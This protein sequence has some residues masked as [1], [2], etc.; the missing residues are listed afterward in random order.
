MLGI[1]QHH[2]GWRLG[3][4]HNL[5]QVGARLGDRLLERGGDRLRGLCAPCG[6]PKSGAQLDEIKI[7]ITEPELRLGGGAGVGEAG[8]R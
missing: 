5:D 2:R 7:G 4:D 8:A 3:R 1:A 6:D